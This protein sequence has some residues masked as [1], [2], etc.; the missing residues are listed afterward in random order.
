MDRTALRVQGI[1]KDFDGLR[2]VDGI[3]L[4]ANRG[5]IL[6]FLGPNGAGKTTSIRII[7]GIFE[8]DE[9]GI[10]IRIGGLTGRLVK[11]RTGYLPEERGLYSDA[12]VLDALV[13]FAELKGLRRTDARQRVLRWL[14]RF[15]LLPWADKKVE[16]LSKGMQQKVQFVASVAHEPD[17]L[18]LDEPF[19][20]LDPLHQDLLKDVVRELRDAGAAILLSA[21]QMNQVEELCDRVFLINRGRQVFYGTLDEIKSRDGEHVVRLRFEGS[22]EPLAALPGVENLAIDGDRASL[23]LGRGA[24]PDAFVRSLPAALTVREFSVTRPPLH[25]IFVRAIEKENRE[26]A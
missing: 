7:L 22:A 12:K 20:G 23:R 5:E 11:E 24:S 6:G 18:V 8:P 10:S 9:G 26:A 25:D 14:D 21:H 4:E 16:K 19:S 2:A 13:Y 1:V 3:S 17:L 15:D